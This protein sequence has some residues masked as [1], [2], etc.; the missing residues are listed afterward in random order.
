MAA[1]VTQRAAVEALAAGDTLAA[2]QFYAALARQ[3]PDNPAFARAA[4][5]LTQLRKPHDPSE[6]GTP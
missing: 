2:A 1:R 4:R 3:Q 5:I 6:G